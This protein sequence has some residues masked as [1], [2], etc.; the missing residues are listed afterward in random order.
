MRSGFGSRR[1]AA[2]PPRRVKFSQRGCYSCNTWWTR[3]I[4]ID[5]SPTADATRLTLPLARRRPRRPRAA[6]FEEVGGAAERPAGRRQLVGREI[7]SGLDEA[8][9]SRHAASSHAVYGS[10]PVIM[11]TWRM[12]LVRST[13]V[14]C[15]ATARA[16]D[17][18]SPSSAT[19]S[20]RVRSV[21]VGFSSMRR[22]R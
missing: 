19:I 20:V 21:D 15:R 5:P 7:R 9:A 8:F 1:R 3:A 16:R 6:C 18:R 14:R 13:P 11:K 2:R 4:A 17:G 10:A 12:A 22:M